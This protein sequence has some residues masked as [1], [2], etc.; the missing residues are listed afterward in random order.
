MFIKEAQLEMRSAF[1]GGFVGQLIAG[2][3]WAVSA[4]VSTWGTPHLGM[5]VLFFVSMLLFHSPN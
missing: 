5:A 3:I 1:L 2:I 4:A